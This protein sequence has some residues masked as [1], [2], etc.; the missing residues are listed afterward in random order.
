MESKKIKLKLNICKF[1]RFFFFLKKIKM[2]RH[3]HFASNF[4]EI[5][6]CTNA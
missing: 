6:L 5:V 4:P 2:N 3:L 1:L